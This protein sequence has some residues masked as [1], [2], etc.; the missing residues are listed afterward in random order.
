MSRIE[1]SSP[2]RTGRSPRGWILLEN[3]SPPV[4]LHHESSGRRRSWRPV[5]GPAARCARS[6]PSPRLF[7]ARHENGRQRAPSSCCGR[8]KPCQLFSTGHTREPPLAR[9]RIIN[10]RRTKMATLGNLRGPRKFERSRYRSGV[11]RPRGG[12][13]SRA[14]HQISQRPRPIRI[15]Q[16]KWQF[17]RVR[18]PLSLSRARNSEFKER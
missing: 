18:I 6:R 2:Q 9:A 8:A 14:S 7:C 4:V 3:V 15:E 16:C 1:S 11:R 13:L 10:A 17:T 12:A 5:V